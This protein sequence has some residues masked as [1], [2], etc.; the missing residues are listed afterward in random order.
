MD[1][2]AAA[3]CL[4]RTGFASW[5]RL[6]AEC[7]R[8]GLQPGDLV[9]ACDD[10]DRNKHRL[11][12]PGA[13][14]GFFRNGNWPIDDMLGPEEAEA[15]KVRL[16]TVERRSAEEDLERWAQSVILTGRRQGMPREAISAALKQRGYVWE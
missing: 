16:V 5:K 13:I 7:Q 6:V 12:G 9:A 11:K 1:W 14:A 15:R 2:A 4:R 8:D 3:E 10:Y